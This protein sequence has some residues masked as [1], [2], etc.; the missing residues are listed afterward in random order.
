MSDMM[1][2]EQASRAAEL[3]DAA[4]AALSPEKAAPLVLA[5]RTFRIATFFTFEQDI[6]ITKYLRSSGVMKAFRD[7]A[8]SPESDDARAALLVTAFDTGA[9][10]PL[11][12]GVLREDGQT[13]TPSRA[14]EQAQFF[15]SLTDPDEKTALLNVLIGSLIGFFTSGRATPKTSQSS[16]ATRP[17]SGDDYHHDGLP[18]TADTGDRDASVEHQRTAHG[19]A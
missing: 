8:E 9:L 18:A 2:Q 3:T 1:L 16:I 13:W 10:F 12:A 11:L 4:T 5:G 6:Y 7:F 14:A 17:P 19:P 15:A